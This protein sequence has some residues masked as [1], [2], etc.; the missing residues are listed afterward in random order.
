V[1]NPSYA[2][3]KNSARRP[4]EMI[5]SVLLPF[6]QALAPLG[7][8]P[9]L[10][11]GHMARSM[12]FN[13]IE[14]LQSALPIDT[15]PPDYKDAIEEQNILG[16]PTQ[17]SRHKSYRHLMELYGLDPS[18]V[19]FRTMRR[20]GQEAPT[21]LP[22]LAMLCTY[23]RDLQLR[24][25][26]ELISTLTPGEHLTRDRMEQHLEESFPSQ[27]SPAM[28]KSL[29]QN[30]NTSWTASG[31]LQGRS[32]KLR[33]LPRSGWA[34]STFAMFLGYLLGLRGQILLDSVF[35]QL[36]AADPAQLVSH[37][38]TASSRGWL[39]LRHGGGVTEIDF[40]ELE[41]SQPEKN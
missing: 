15:T 35:G 19:I 20:L 3:L 31:H 11:G 27:F 38:Q 33:T 34:S 14:V 2:S 41:N 17:S 13:E 36:V 12:M 10:T 26:F 24:R 21:D 39:R 4:A 8:T 1:K 16:K 29:A 9:N 5:Q 22:L 23:C 6:P 18:L 25:S 7:F 30:I 32:K 40:S 37:L 28:K